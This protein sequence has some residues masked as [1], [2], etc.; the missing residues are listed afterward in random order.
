MRDLVAKMDADARVLFLSGTP[1]Q[2]HQTRFENLLQLLQRTGETAK[3]LTGRVIYR[4]KD[5]VADWEGDPVFPSRQINPPILFDAGPLYRQWLR[6]IHEFYSPYGVLDERDAGKR[7]AG[8]RCAQALQWAAS[9]PHAGLGYLV[10]QAIRAGWSLQPRN[11]TSA[12]SGLRP[13]RNGAI[14]EP[15]DALLNR[16]RKDIGLQDESGELEDM[17]ETDDH[18][19]TDVDHA[20]LE[21][22][23]TV[24]LVLKEAGDSKWNLIRDRVPR[25]PGMS[26]SFV[27]SANRDGHGFA[28]YLSVFL[29][30][31]GDHRRS[32]RQVRQ[33]RSID[34]G[35]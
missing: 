3:D 28:H 18:L 16:I 30:A 14:D 26:A 12:L 9:S 7:A 34:F 31:S 32:D 27:C 13:Y 33:E 6:A 11:L 2:G 15:V 17:E 20:G 1:H 23:I 22:L 35:V 10:R 24:A 4:T 5:D 19:S 25:R 29:M 8:W 21:E